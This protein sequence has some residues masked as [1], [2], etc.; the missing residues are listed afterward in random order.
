MLVFVKFIDKAPIRKGKLTH[1]TSI[2]PM[3]LPVIK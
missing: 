2:D 1:S 3:T